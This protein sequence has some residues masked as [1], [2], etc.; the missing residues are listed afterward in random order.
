MAEPVLQVKNISKHFPGVKALDGIS[1]EL[2]KGEVLCIAGENGAGKSTFIKTLSG[3]C[4]PDEGEIILNGCKVEMKTPL[5]ALKLGF[6]VV[7]QEHKLINNLTVA[8]NIFFGRFPMKSGMVDYKKL[9]ADTETLIKRLGI[10]MSPRTVVGGITASKGHMVEI[11]KALSVE[12]KIMILD[13]PSASISDSEM[14][15][16]FSIIKKLKAEGHSFIYI[17]HRLKELFEIGDR[18]AVFKDGKLMGVNPISELTTEKI[19][20]MMVGRE[21]GSVFM[22][23]DRKLG[24]EAIR[25]E[26]LTNNKVTDCSFHIHAGEVV[27]FAGLVGAGRSELAESIFGYR[28]KSAGKIFI[29]GREVKI[30]KPKDAIHFKI[31]FVTEDRK[32]TG[33]ILSK[34]V[35]MNIT[36]AVLKRLSRYGF[37]SEKKEKAEIASSIKSLKIKTPSEKQDAEYLSGGNQQKVVL[38]KWLLTHSKILI[39][40]EPTKGIDVGTKQ[41]FYKIIDD[42]ARQGI[43]IMLIS[44]ELSEIIG[45]S[46]R[47]YVMSDGKIVGELDEKELTEERIAGYAMKEEDN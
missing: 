20:S 33:V 2:N 7:Y 9:N 18:V 38:A 47:V 14:D 21:I 12:A 39:C 27:G 1:L 31:G 8:E 46:N 36:F 3:V 34:S 32:T 26:G 6:S 45:L 15:K 28:K 35:G 4:Q 23:K 43:A 5:T 41:E 30:A 13:E 42:L 11:M 25:V 29:D 16:L 22:P 40:D 44:S 19:I 17:S 37:V 10:D 24:A